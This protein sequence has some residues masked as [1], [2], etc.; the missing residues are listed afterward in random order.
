[1]SERARTIA[2]W[3]LVIMASVA[4][5][6]ALVVGY[7]RRAAVDSD[8]FANRA[9][10]AV[11][12]D[13]VRTLA[14]EQITDRLI[15]K[16]HSDLIA[17]RPLIES[18]VSSV[19]GAPAFTGA[20]RSGVR[21]VH[22]AVFDRDQHTFTLAVADVGSMVAAGLEAVQPGAARQVRG[23]QRV[24]LVHRDIGTAAARAAHTVKLL[25]WVF[26]LVALAA[27]AGAIWLARDRRQVM[28]RLGIG[29][30]IGGFLLAVAL[31]VVRSAVIDA[32]TTSRERDAVG[33]V[34]DAFLKDLHTAAW[35][36]AASGAVVAAAAASLIRPVDIDVPLRRAAAWV[37]TE[38]ERPVWKVVRGV[39]LIAAG[40]L[41]VLDRDAVLQ[42]IFTA[43][44][45]YLV[46]AGVMCAALARVSAARS[47]AG[48]R[49][50]PPPADRHPRGDAV[51]RRAQLRRAHGTDRH[52][53]DDGEA[54]LPLPGE[55]AA[56]GEDGIL[57]NGE[58]HVTENHD[59]EDRPIAPR[60]DQPAQARHGA[61]GRRIARSY[62]SWPGRDLCG[63][64]VH[65][66][67]QGRR[68]EGRGQDRGA[69]WKR[70]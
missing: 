16:R 38:P 39:A 23:T 54:E 26:L 14:A 49:Q 21:D 56:D 31:G 55:I 28:L 43:V 69:V 17:A 42:L 4:I 7:V 8:Q 22:R 47:R 68:G 51:S 20:F 40:L 29:A 34:W 64:I 59:Q 6:L 53:H 30:A 60:I 52:D 44:G 1:L 35:I 9:T 10:A 3:A 13:P 11:R 65:R 46:Y 37:T 62:E 18:V 25:A 19:V 27:G 5:V 67:V 2:V 63:T 32:G 57:G 61:T 48:G 70:C 36:L 58:P 41:F 15:L 66:A 12:S 50:H 45:L 24:D 33:A